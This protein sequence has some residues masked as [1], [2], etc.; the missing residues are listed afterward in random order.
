M[1]LIIF[2]VNLWTYIYA[3]QYGSHIGHVITFN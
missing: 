3:V 2:N 1:G